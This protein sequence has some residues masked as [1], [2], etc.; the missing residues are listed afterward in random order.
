MHIPGCTHTSELFDHL[1]V[2]LKSSLQYHFRVVHLPTPLCTY[3]VG[4]VSGSEKRG[5]EAGKELMEVEGR[6]GERE[7]G[8]ER[9]REKERERERE[10]QL[11][12][13]TPFNKRSTH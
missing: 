7:G 6:E 3:W 2:I 4:V 9:E 12:A 8:E 5:E 11:L 13:S 1:V 10:R